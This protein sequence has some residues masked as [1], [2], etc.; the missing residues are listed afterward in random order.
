M[1]NR[2]ILFKLNSE[3][4]LTGIDIV[5]GTSIIIITIVVVTM[6][7]MNIDLGSKSIN[8]TAGATRIA[9][10][11]IEQIE[12]M[13]YDEIGEIE[14]T[15][16]NVSE[17]SGELKNIKDIINDLTDPINSRY[18][19]INTDIGETTEKTVGNSIVIDGKEVGPAD[20]FFGV[21][22]P[23]GYRVEITVTDIHRDESIDTMSADPIPRF[24]LLKEITINVVYMV[25]NNE[26]NVSVTMVKNRESVKD[27]NE[28][29]LNSLSES[30]SVDI[31]EI[32]PVKYNVYSD[33]YEIT[34]QTDTEWYSYSSGEW[35][36]VIITDSDSAS[37]ILKSKADTKDNMYVWIPRYTKIR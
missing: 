15:A 11:M 7:A 2:I 12:K 37:D 16:P 19:V 17:P 22:I 20:I 23:R 36:R 10:T 4:G 25:G 6:I 27:C 24:N 13:Y 32:V 33:K 26:R 29:D 34:T 28:P 35:A 1:K 18:D 3:K 8:R 5:V 21:K 31:S 9:T 30:I 14:L